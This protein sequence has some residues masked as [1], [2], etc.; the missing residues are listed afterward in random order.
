MLRILGLLTAD[1][2]IGSYLRRVADGERGPE[3]AAQISFRGRERMRA[4]VVLLVRRS[5]IEY[6][7]RVAG[8]MR[9]DDLRTRFDL[10]Q[11]TALAPLSVH[12]LRSRLLRSQHRPIDA[13]RGDLSPSASRGAEEILV[14]HVPTLGPVLD[15]M[16]AAQARS[17]PAARLD[18]LARERDALASAVA[19]TG[20]PDLA[21]DDGFVL[22]READGSVSLFP[23]A[24]A[25]SAAREDPMI[26]H[27]ATAFLG[28]R[29]QNSDQ[30]SVRTFTDGRR[31]LLVANVNRWP[32]ETVL[33]P[34]LIYYHRQ[35]HSYVTVQYKRMTQQSGRWSYRPDEQLRKQLRDMAAVDQ[36]CA[37]VDDQARWRWVPTPSFHKICR[38]ETST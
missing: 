17:V 10:G 32:I 22:E 7:A 33:G 26:E 2:E 29:L 11:V 24:S 35:R 38:L 37:A 28:W 16:F 36:A 21:P 9:G 34:D 31:T 8:A 14:G 6:I 25:A 18:A 3:C 5:K 12:Q 20:Y 4:P 27:D 30:L 13:G 1:D 19:F 23:H 15:A